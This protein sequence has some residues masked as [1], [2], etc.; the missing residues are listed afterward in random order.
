MPALAAVRAGSCGSDRLSDR[1]RLMSDKG[2]A[3]NWGR[4]EAV[5]LATDELLDAA[6]RA[7]AEVGVARA[8]MAD[9]CRHAGCARS[10][11]YRYFENR[12]ALHL[13]YVNRASLR[14]AAR[15]AHEVPAGTDPRSVLTERVLFGIRAV[16]E[17]P[18]LASWFTP[19]NMAVPIALSSD[20]EVLAALTEA[21]T[22]DV[23]LGAASA[24]QRETQGRWLLRSIISLLAMPVDDP[25]EERAVIEDFMVPPL[26][27]E[28]TTSGRARR[29]TLEAGNG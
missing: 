13:A 2:S 9:V 6:G 8:T 14:I 23:G 3:A 19:E 11:L 24:A 21:F 10:T 20:S 27:G 16:R 18:M 5:D 1:I 25:D 12:A 4:H 26:L 15:L 28:F 7:F 29:T 17:D 22:D